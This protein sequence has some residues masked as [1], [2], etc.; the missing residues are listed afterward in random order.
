VLESLIVGPVKALIIG[1]AVFVP[2]ERM[3]SLRP[4]QGPLRRDWARDVFT[5][6]VNG[7]LLYGIL[8]ITLGGVDGAAALCVPRLRHWVAAQPLAAQCIGALVIGDLG[9]YTIHRLQHASAWLWRFHS[10]HHSAEELDWLIGFRFHPLDLF[11]VRL[12]SLGPL[13][14][15]NFAPSAVATFVAISGWQSWLVHANVKMPYGPLR[16]LLV[17][18]EF[19]H[20]HHSAE[21]EA[22]DRNYASLVASWDVLFGTVYLPRGRRPQRYGIEDRL[23]AGLIGRLI[24][25]FRSRVASSPDAAAATTPAMTTGPLSSRAAGA[26]ML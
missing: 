13:L 4:A 2:F 22:H 10:V 6:L 1:A 19:H 15:L 25:P 21:R 7:L 8:L 24:Y 5:G 20:W 23:P 14:A 11:L 16:W 18:P 9:V 3:A 26:P 17:S 12:A